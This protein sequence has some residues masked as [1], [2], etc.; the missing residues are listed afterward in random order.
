MSSNDSSLRYQADEKPPVT[1]ALTLGLQLTALSVSATILITTVV[2][3]AGGQGEAYLAWTVFAAVVIG[4]GATM[5]QAFRLG[6]FG[7][8]HVLMMGSS[9]AFL[10]VCID[11]L[12]KGGPATMATLVVVSALFQ[13]V[14]SDRLSLFRR[15]LTPSVSGTVLMLIP[16]SVM[17]PVLNLL[18]DAPE[19]SPALGAPLSALATVLVICGLTLKASG[20]LRLWAPVFGVLTGSLIA[21]FFGLYDTA[22]VLEASW[23]G[24]PPVEW[25]GLDLGFGPVFWSLLPGFLLAATIGSI[26]TI[27]SAAAAQRV[28][29]RGPRAVDFRA[30]QGAVATDGLSNL[31]SGLAG[32]AP[33]TSYTTGASL[34]QLTGVASRHVGI[35]AGAVFLALAFLP[36]ALA[37]VLA[38]PGP[39]FAAYLIVMMA[40]LFMIGVQMIAQDGIDYRKN[41]IVGVSFWLGL[42]FQSGVVFPEFFSKFAGGFMNNGMT[43]GGLVAVL[44]TLFVEVTEPRP[45][46]MEAPLDTSSLPG[47]REFLGRFAST[48]G[49]DEAMAKRLGGVCEEILLTLLGPDEGEEQ[50][51]RSL[52]LLA[53]KDGGA[54]VLEFIAAAGEAENLEDRVA[55]LGEQTEEAQME[56]EVSLRLL[57]HH[58]ASVR[59]QQY[60]GAD[61]VTVRVEAP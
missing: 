50:N 23:I 53:K 1:V 6:R 38:I 47:F 19:G 13:F 43:A 41:L 20:T 18:K 60:H 28:S 51:G 57:R 39:V 56:E 2:M 26:R 49:W 55:L 52:A 34:A 33:N 10:A 16:V 31:L 48:G 3:R 54:A 32:T 45:S 5:L 42:A 15:I 11:A 36:K 4:G 24:L 46:R 7:S 14:I 44:M 40:V 25:P 58:S 59:H 9:A 61:I 29:W 8:G 12:V 30:V 35:A 22:R 17:S 37:L 21:A 27:S